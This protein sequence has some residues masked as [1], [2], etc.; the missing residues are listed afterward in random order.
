MATKSTPRVRVPTQAKAGELIEIKTLISH[1]MESG[2]R[3]D[4]A[5]KAIPRKII[6]KF[7]AEFNG[8]PVFSATLEPAI[9][10]N[11][12][13]QFFTKV[14]E[15]GTFKFTWTDDDGSVTTAEEKITVA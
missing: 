14:E 11:P 5:G 15:S 2:Q 6:N 10:A 3:K 13:M 4:A 7:T 9:A 1:E 8:K 12:Y